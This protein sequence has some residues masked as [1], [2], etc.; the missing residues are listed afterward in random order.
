MADVLADV[1]ADELV[2]AVSV[3][4]PHAASVT[5]NDAAQVTSATE[6]GRRSEFTVVTVQPHRIPA[7]GRPSVM[8]GCRPRVQP[9][10]QRN[11]SYR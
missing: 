11:V 9:P 5:T 6:E 8:F 3:S 4:E 1:L 2:D 10:S 7:D